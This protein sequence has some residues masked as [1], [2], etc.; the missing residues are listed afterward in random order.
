MALFKKGMMN[1]G[2]EELI[3][4]FIQYEN[5]IDIHRGNTLAVLEDANLFL[6]VMRKELGFK[7]S[8]SLKVMTVM[9]TAEA[10]DE[11]GQ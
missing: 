2:S 10:R 1:W 5:N 3:K 9:L 6:K 7:D 4:N 8:N 11:L